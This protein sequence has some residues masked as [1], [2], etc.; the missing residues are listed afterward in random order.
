MSD[1]KSTSPVTELEL[2]VEAFEVAQTEGEAAD[3]RRFLP[4]ATH[5]LYLSVLRELVRVDMEYGWRRGRPRRLDDYQKEFPELF[6]DRKSLQDITFEEYRLRRLAG[7]NPRPV[8]YQQRFGVITVDWPKPAT[9]L[10]AEGRLRDA[11]EKARAQS[12]DSR[13]DLDAAL[14]YLETLVR[15]AESSPEIPEGPS[16][17]PKRASSE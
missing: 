17:P 14:A 1:P 8:E 4:P 11:G 13:Y 7:E 16:G 15:Q 3:L 5:R 2:Y 10:S 6:K 12:G 9:S